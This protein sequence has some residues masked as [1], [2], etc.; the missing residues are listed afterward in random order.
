MKA[1]VVD[2]N[3]ISIFSKYSSIESQQAVTKMMN[4]KIDT[5]F[6]YQE[7]LNINFTID[8]LRQG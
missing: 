2:E 3:I 1:F 6:K 4:D 8:Q 5:V 7:S